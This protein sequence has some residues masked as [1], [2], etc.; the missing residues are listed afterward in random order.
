MP[1][2]NPSIHPSI[3]PTRPVN[4]RATRLAISILTSQG[5]PRSRARRLVRVWEGRIGDKPRLGAWPRRL[6][7]K[8]RHNEL[9]RAVV[10]GLAV[11]GGGALITI[12]VFLLGE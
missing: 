8:V 1:E 10:I 2:P 11:F 9:L 7:E 12:G 3:S 5:S 4:G 6:V